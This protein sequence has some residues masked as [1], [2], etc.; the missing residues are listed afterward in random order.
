MRAIRY[1]L[2]ALLVTAIATGVPTQE[3]EIQQS[4]PSELKPW[5]H[6]DLNNDADNF[7]FAIVT[8]RTGGHRPGVF[9]DGVRKLNLMQPEFVMSVG[10]LIEGYTTDIEVLARQWNQFNGF[11]DQLEMPFF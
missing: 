4:L 1:G 10:D 8:D 5:T 7:Q 2:S 3:A 11:V 6:L 9:M